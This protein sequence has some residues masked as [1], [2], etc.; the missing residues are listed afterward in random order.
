MQKLSAVART[1]NIY[2]S[3]MVLFLFFFSAKDVV[4]YWYD[5][6]SMYDYSKPYYDYRTAHFTQ[7]VWNETQY[8]GCGWAHDPQIEGLFV[9][10]NYWKQ[11]NM[12][13]EF[14]ANVFRKMY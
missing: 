3:Y 8:V 9:V 10:C 11:G 4:T 6:I 14:R 13:G 7:I 2:G 1:P 12:Q 5:E